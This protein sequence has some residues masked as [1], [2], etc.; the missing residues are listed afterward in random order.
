[1]DTQAAGQGIHAQTGILIAAGAG[2]Q[3]M[4]NRGQAEIMDLAP[5]VLYLLGLPVPCEMDGRILDEMLDPD[6]LS[7]RPPQRLPL[8]HRL[9][10]QSR[11]QEQAASAEQRRRL[12]ERL[13]DLG[14]LE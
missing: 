3:R 5:T 4:H 10:I 6:W 11:I 12:E 7:T 9:E 1:M 2:M 8:S 14:Y 13:G